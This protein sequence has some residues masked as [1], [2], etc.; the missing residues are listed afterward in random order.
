MQAKVGARDR[1][2]DMEPSKSTKAKGQEKQTRT[3]GAEHVSLGRA[4]DICVSSFHRGPAFKKLLPSLN[5]MGGIYVY[6]RAGDF[7]A[8]IWEGEEREDRSTA[9]PLNRSRSVGDPWAGGWAVGRL[10]G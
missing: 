2:R 3:V 6:I 4:F 8:L 10:S 9:Q 1:S 7:G 5:W